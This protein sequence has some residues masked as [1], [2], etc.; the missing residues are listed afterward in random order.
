MS[1]VRVETSIAGAFL[2]EQQGG[3][4]AQRLVHRSSLRTL[5]WIFAP[6]LRGRYPAGSA[7][8]GT[9]RGSAGAGH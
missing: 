3:G 6:V 7:A 8:P 1:R 4:S 5:R 2:R 9:G